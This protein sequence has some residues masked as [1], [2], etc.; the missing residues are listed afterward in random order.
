MAENE[1]KR[2]EPAKQQAGNCVVKLI[3]KCNKDGE[4]TFFEIKRNIKIRRLLNTF[5]QHA[6]LDYR[7]TRFVINH[8]TFSHE[9]TPNQLGLQDNDQIDALID[10]NGA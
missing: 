6:S 10:G 3:V 1:S 9:K 4:E 5:C 8:C 7:S 2:V